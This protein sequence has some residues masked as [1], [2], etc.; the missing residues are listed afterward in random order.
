[1]E[2]GQKPPGPALS[3]ICL[4]NPRQDLT[5]EKDLGL[6]G[7]LAEVSLLECPRCGRHW[8]RYFYELEAFTASGRWYLGVITAEQALHLTAN[9]A[10]SLF[11]SLE[12][13][14]YGGSYYGGQSG[15]SSGP[16]P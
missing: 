15:K 6:D 9:N 2:I 5:R 3:C 8:L 10:Q 12:W 16:L 11:E 4:D 13:Y 1:M 7:N 14:Y